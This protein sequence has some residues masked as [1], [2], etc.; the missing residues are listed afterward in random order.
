M[1]RAS[2]MRVGIPGDEKMLNDQLKSFF[3][4]SFQIQTKSEMNWGV[5]GGYHLF[6]NLLPFAPFEQGSALKW[7]SRRGV[8]ISIQ[9]ER[10]PV[11]F[12]FQK[13]KKK[14]AR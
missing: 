11:F 4:I 9:N 10:D 1:N 8:P 2:A 6:S 5:Q 3:Q 12:I 14:T 7:E 13:K